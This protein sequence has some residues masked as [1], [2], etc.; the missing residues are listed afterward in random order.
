MPAVNHKD[1]VMI[2]SNQRRFTVIVEHLYEIVKG[3][4][5]FCTYSFELK[6]CTEDNDL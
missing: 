4:Q 3:K 2:R 6:V 1:E 5:V